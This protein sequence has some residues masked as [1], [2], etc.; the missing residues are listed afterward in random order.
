MDARAT[1]TININSWKSTYKNIVS[2]GFL[3]SLEIEPRI[4]AAEKRFLRSDMDC[5]VAVDSKNLVVGFANFGPCR[6]KN[7]DADAELYAIYIADEA[8]GFGV[9]KNL[10][11]AGYEATQKRGY[12]KMMVSVFTKNEKAC[13]FYEKMGGKF[14]GYDRVVLEEVSYATT[15][16]IWNF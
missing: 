4:E 9:G 14:Y 7:V 3:D 6:E 5:F 2:A 13:G 8:H 12:Q 16:Y 10:F 15:T 11:L 1:A